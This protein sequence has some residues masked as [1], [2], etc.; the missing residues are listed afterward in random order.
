MRKTGAPTKWLWTLK[1]PD[2][3]IFRTD[4][5]LAFLTSRPEDFPNPKNAYQALYYV[6]KVFSSKPD[7]HVYN[8][9]LILNIE[10]N[11]VS[12][13]LVN[14]AGQ[15]FGSL[16]VLYRVVGAGPTTWRCRCDCGATKDVLASNLVEGRITSCGCRATANAA[17]IGKHQANFVDLTGL[18]FGKLVAVFYD[19]LR[20]KWVCRCDCGGSC[21]LATTYLTNGSRTDC[22]CEAAKAAAKRVQDGT[23]GNVMGTNI[24]A[25]Q[26]IMDGKI[27]ASNT[28][29]ATGVRIIHRQSGV[30]YGAR[31]TVRG[32]DINLGLYQ[33]MEE[34]IKARKGAEEKYFGGILEAYRKNADAPTIPDNPGPLYSLRAR[35]MAAG[36]TIT[37]L[38]RRV[39]MSY[40]YIRN[41]E[42]LQQPGSNA[43]RSALAKALGCT[44]DDLCY[45]P[46]EDNSREPT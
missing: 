19:N 9:W 12:S 14:L 17:K 24:N 27:R 20:R 26:H 40:S 32:K 35:R 13:R 6:R 22:G 4:N 45:N 1:S 42:T 46:D 16:V 44:V 34:A 11:I 29:G 2:G 23:N 39:G 36:L 7:G 3:Q 8:G 21:M 38:V 41:L 33:S 43:V 30:V 18:R 5:L 25:I 10:P 15:R 28:S 31:I 37:D